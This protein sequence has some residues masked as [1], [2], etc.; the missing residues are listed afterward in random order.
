MYIYIYTHRY[1]MWHGNGKLTVTTF[2]R[3]M[4]FAHSSIVKA[5]QP[6][7]ASRLMSVG[8]RSLSTAYQLTS[9]CLPK[10]AY[11][12]R[13]TITCNIDVILYYS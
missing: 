6:A 1:V 12:T 8:S 5:C 2:S 10:G 4:R 9:N 13:L 7:Y 3:P 11:R